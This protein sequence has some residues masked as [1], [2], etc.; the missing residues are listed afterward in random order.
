[1]ARRTLRVHPE[2]ERDLAHGCDWYASHSLIAAEQF[3]DELDTALALVR[4]APERWPLYRHGTRRFVMS[5]YP[6][7]IIYRVTSDSVDVYAV[8]HAKR[9]PMYWRSR[10]FR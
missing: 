4:E 10:R 9:R 1:M 2:A 7:S 8:A 5:S 3:L 6:Y